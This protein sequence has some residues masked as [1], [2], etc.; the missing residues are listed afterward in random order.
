MYQ[1]KFFKSKQLK[2]E[3]EILLKNKK[4]YLYV[5]TKLNEFLLNPF[6]KK[7]TVRK[8]KPKSENLLRLRLDKIRVIFDIDTGN[9]II[10]VYRIGYRKDIYK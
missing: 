9:K 4:D 10:I 6:A 2:K 5:K 7:W 8:M 1:I 3:Q